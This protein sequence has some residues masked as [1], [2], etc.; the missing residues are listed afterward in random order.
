MFQKQVFNVSWVGSF[1]DQ[2]G[3]LF[4]FPHPFW[5]ELIRW[6][7]IN[8]VK[9]GRWRLSFDCTGANLA[10]WLCLIA[11]V[12][13][14]A[15]NDVT[16][17]KW[18]P[19]QCL[20]CFILEVPLPASYSQS[21]QNCHSPCCDRGSTIPDVSPAVTLSSLILCFFPSFFFNTFPSCLTCS[22]GIAPT[23]LCPPPALD[24][25]AAVF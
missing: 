19:V 11:V 5:L 20:K 9:Q 14:L 16:R 8:G 2:H 3:H 21:P 13:V 17:T 15:P 18:A 4:F 12:H 24:L 1:H 22:R 10:R 6:W 25:S 7:H 23:F